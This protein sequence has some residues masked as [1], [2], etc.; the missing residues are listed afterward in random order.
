MMSTLTFDG[1]SLVY[2]TPYNPGL[3]ADFKARI[4]PSDRQWDGARKVW[5]VAPQHGPTLA[6][7]TE[8]Y[9]GER[10]TVPTTAPTVKPSETRVLELRYIGVTKDRGGDE[11]SAFGYMGG[12]W[13]VIFPEPVLR[14]WFDAPRRPDEE[15]TLYQTLGVKRD[16]CGADLKAAYRRLSRQWHP[17][18]CRE[19]GADQVFMKIK[20]AYDLLSDPSKRARY[21]AGLALTAT[22]GRK[23]EAVETL[24]GYRSPL[25]CG[26]LLCD[27]QER[28]GRFVVSEILNWQDIEDAYGRVL[29]VS[30]PLGAD[31]PVEVWA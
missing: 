28:L 15:L 6:Q 24:T 23:T 30:W 5:R 27:G 12:Q 7:L 31:K 9:L 25:R 2:Q 22:L 18:V 10:I 17:D 20:A 8:Q 19:P 26:L 11:R 13:T 16:V 1:A 4:P 3:V 29:S 21:D 14:A